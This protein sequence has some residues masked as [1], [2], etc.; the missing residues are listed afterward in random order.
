[1]GVRALSVRRVAPSHAQH[2]LRVPPSP[3]APVPPRTLGNQTLLRLLSTGAVQVKLR[4]SEPNDPDEQEADRVADWMLRR[5]AAPGR[6]A[7][8]CEKSPIPR[9]LAIQRRA[10]GDPVGPGSA[11]VDD[12]LPGLDGGQPL[13]A[14]TRAFFEPRFGRDFSR[15]RVHA[16]ARAAESADAVGAKAYTFGRDIVF[17]AGLYQPG[18]DRGQRLLAHELAHVHQARRAPASVRRVPKNPEGTPFEA[19]VFPHW[20]TPLRDMPAYEARRLVD[21]PRH[22]RVTVES[23]RAWLR[24]RTV[25]DGQPLTGFISHEQLRRLPGTKPQAKAP[26]PKPNTK[27][28]PLHG[29]FT[30]ASGYY[31]R[32]APGNGEILGKLSYQTMAVTVLEAKTLWDAAD[33]REYIWYKVDFS[34]DDFATIVMN[35]SLELLEANLGQAAG[36]STA[37]QRHEQALKA[38]PGTTGWLREQA[39]AVAAM[40][41]DHFLRL[42]AEFEK[43]HPDPLQQRLS[44]LRQIGEEP[45]VPGNIAV[46]AGEDVQ[47]QI[48]RRQRP[49]DPS[50]WKILLE[51][52]QVELPNG[53]IVDIHHFFLGVESLID[54]SRRSESRTLTKYGVASTNIGQSYAAATWSGDVG[55]A[56]ADFVMGKSKDWEEALVLGRSEDERLAFYFRTRAPDFDLLADIDA[57]G[58][59]GLVPSGGTAGEGE[60]T[61][62]TELVTTFYGPAAQTA[63]AQEQVVKTGRARG[64]RNLLNHYG[65]TSTTD[66]KLQADARQRIEDQIFIFSKSWYQV[67][68]GSYAENL[69]GPGEGTAA[70]LAYASDKM[71]DI[72][73]DWLE[74][75]AAK[76]GVALDEETAPE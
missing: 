38:N 67:K 33:E 34:A 64:I 31:V 37:S 24:V 14:A 66:L 2:P 35:R 17:A 56:A 75:Q 48:N 51:A 19:E 4:V 52:K 27:L 26:A 69:S 8:Q 54:D 61:S 18:M 30:E 16:D 42:L 10:H 7:G 63:T 25:V 1:M 47:N 65:F 6:D 62:L 28:P 39:F 49:L 76:Y 21:L 71:T 43:A 12:P 58:A 41:W 53:E 22:H 20:S 45:D 15:V 60:V 44:R 46:G 40:P 32:A 59:Y 36:P 9:P 74:S 23:G 3:P 5:P 68:A 72:F 13:S 29:V 57:W 70:D 50:R 55:G 73:L 11:A